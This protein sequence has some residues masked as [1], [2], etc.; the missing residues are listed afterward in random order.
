MIPRT[1]Q[2]A[3]TVATV[4][5]ASEIDDYGNII[6]NGYATTGPNTANI[7]A[8][9]YAE[10]TTA[11]VN[12]PSITTY[13]PML[14]GWTTNYYEY[15]TN[16]QPNGYKVNPGDPTMFGYRVNS[17]TQETG[18]IATTGWISPGS[19]YTPGTYLGEALS[20]GTGSG[21]TADIVV[22]LPVGVDVGPASA[23]SFVSAGTGYPPMNTLFSGGSTVTLTGSGSGLTVQGRSNS[24]FLVNLTGVTSGGT[25]YRVGDTFTVT[26]GTGVGQV[27]AVGTGGTVTNFTLVNPGTGYTPGDAL[28]APGLPDGSGFYGPIATVIPDSGTGAEPLWGQ[29]PARYNQNEVA[30]FVPPNNNP[31]AIPYSFIYPVANNLNQ[32]PL[33]SLQALPPSGGG[34]GGSAAIGK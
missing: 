17:F 22:T 8:W 20:G 1:V 15:Y 13:Q 4:L 24:G 27:D 2:M 19:G 5:S 9:Q 34:G 14:R 31:Q 30:D 32:P 18:S 3:K 21:A 10:T 29:T 33:G 25:G 12:L 11:P 26:P 28:E 23:V 6:L 7:K 16:L